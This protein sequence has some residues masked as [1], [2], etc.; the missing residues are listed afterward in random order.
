MPEFKE[1]NEHLLARRKNV[2]TF[3]WLQRQNLLRY[4]NGF[5]P[6]DGGKV[7]SKVCLS[8]K[9]KMNILSR[10]SEHP[11]ARRKNVKTFR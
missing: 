1:K 2:K 8:L 4:L 3:R 5:L 9:K 10:P 11:L 7:V 6:D